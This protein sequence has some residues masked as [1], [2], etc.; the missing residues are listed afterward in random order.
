[1][2]QQQQLVFDI[3]AQPLSSA[4]LAYGRTTALQ[5]SVDAA[6]VRGVSAPA[7]SGEMAAGT[8]LD[9]L[10]AG[11][12]LYW[13]NVGNGRIVVE[14]AGPLATGEDGSAILLD[15]ISVSP[16]G[17]GNTPFQEGGAT[18]HISQAQILRRRGATPGDIFKGTA[19]V[20][21]AANHN[22]SQLDV[23]IRGMQGQNRVK[24]AIDGTQ[25][26]STT[27]RGYV[28]VDERVYLDPDMIAAI[29]IAKGPS[30]D[31][32]GAGTTGG[33]V[34]ARTLNASDIVPEGETQGWRLRL[35]TS[36]NADAPPNSTPSNPEYEQR[37]NAPGLFEDENYSGS[38]AYGYL[39][40]NFDLLL[41][42]ATRKRGNYFAGEHGPT[43]YEFDGRD[44]ALSFTQ[45][46]E[47]VFNSSEDSQT[48]MTKATY[49]WGEDHRI[50]LGFTRHE[51]E[52]GESMGSL[53]FQQDN[54]FRQVKLSD[55]TADTYTARYRWQPESD[56][57]DLKANLWATDVYGTTRAVAASLY[58]PPTILP[59]DEPRY[60]ETQ[61]Y[62]ADVS[63]KSLTT[64]FDRDLTLQ[65]GVSYQLEDI[66][67]HEYCSRVFT[68]SICVVMKPSIGTREIGSLFTTAD[69]QLWD[70]VNLTGGLRYDAWRLKDEAPDADPNGSERD[71]GRLNPTIGILWEAQPG[72]Q[73]YARYA[74]GVRPPTL[75]ETMGS[76]ANATPNPDLKVE[77]AHNYELGTNLLRHDVIQSGD[78]VGVKLSAFHNSYDNYVSRVPSNG[79]PGQPVF[80]FDNIKRASF[81][82][83]ELSGR[84][85]SGNVFA[86]TSVTY[87]TGYEFCY[88]EGCQDV[89][90]QYDYAANHLPPELMLSLTLGAKLM[91]ERLTLGATVDRAGARMAPLTTSD[92]QRTAMWEPYTVGS[93]FASYGITDAI[94]VDARVENLSDRYY[95]DALDGWT[96]SPGRTVSLGLDWRF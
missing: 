26:T 2:A 74:E 10:L 73:F 5:I 84:Y 92:R 31:A 43:T 68:N 15:P 27:W 88:T 42:Y 85:D 50:Q 46:G 11:T 76:D 57:I 66:N 96:P 35:G 65:Y 7:V 13:R 59:A 60:S 20:I 40:E 63:N 6:A 67:A 72:L 78:T 4:L 3:P 90:V 64:L 49:Y 79:G 89:A 56:L 47:E 45:P 70:N 44:Y 21:A 22:G 91:D 54:G 80:T 77:T 33:V 30:G 36:D 52:F 8:A 61:T 95:I 62:G 28:G 25:Q 81:T 29:D 82:G 39:G 37:D 19:G 69:L 34:A 38:L 55:M 23:N 75:R 71:G 18:A 32:A 87:Y 12:G 41:A 17:D 9:R 94:S 16:F 83:I 14:R 58:F 86:E 48:L 24:V 51:T 53:M 93:V 1:M